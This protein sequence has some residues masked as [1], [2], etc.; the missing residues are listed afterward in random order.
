MACVKGMV[1]MVLGLAAMNPGV[2]LAFGQEQ[3]LDDVRS[4]LLAFPVK[5][6]LKDTKILLTV[7]KKRTGSILFW[8][9]YE[10]YL[11]WQGAKGDVVIYH[12]V[13]CAGGFTGRRDC[14]SGLEKI[15]TGSASGKFSYPYHHDDYFRV[16]ELGIEIGIPVYDYAPK[17]GCSDT[18]KVPHA[19]GRMYH[20]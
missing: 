19:E 1:M 16:C 20:L 8:K 11:E 15:S 18:L 13:S 9:R 3:S 6:R 2:E 10:S 17:N 14:K 7:V 5:Q 12:S 4:G